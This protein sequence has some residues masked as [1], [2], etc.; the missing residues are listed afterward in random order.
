VSERRIRLLEAYHDGELGWL[1]RWRARRLLSRDADARAILASLE[2][3]G[4]LL[5]EIEAEASAP[6]LWEAV[7]LR[8]PALD[9]RRS[10]AAA[11]EASSLP[12]W[13]GAG[14]AT[15]AAALALVIGLQLV[16]PSGSG[17]VRW[18]D[19]RG[20]PV[21][22]LQD[23]RDATIIWLLEAPAEVSGRRGRAVS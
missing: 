10:G 15:A 13:I 5:R 8:L 17:A 4:G 20:S 11:A 6:D 2:T 14:L 12:R 1:D 16:P 22:V 18:L 9:A 23:D 3:V 19:S 7:R 21:V